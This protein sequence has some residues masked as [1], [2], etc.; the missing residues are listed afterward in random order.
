MQFIAGVMKQH[1]WAPLSV[2][3]I[4]QGYTNPCQGVSALAATLVEAINGRI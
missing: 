3:V 4:S 1:S 2:A